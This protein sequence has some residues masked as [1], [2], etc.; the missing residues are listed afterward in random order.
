MARLPQKHLVWY[1]T[2]FVTVFNC[3]YDNQLHLSL[4]LALYVQLSG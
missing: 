4:E 3:P 1:S 2:G